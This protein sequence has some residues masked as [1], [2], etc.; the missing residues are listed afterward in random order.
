ME[1][2]ILHSNS[3]F[4]WVLPNDQE[5]KEISINEEFIAKNLNKKKSK[6]YKY[7]RGYMRYFLS[8]LF[9]INPLQVPL[10]SNPGEAPQLPPEFGFL[11]ISHTIDAL[12]I[13]WSKEKVG[14]D[15]ERYDRKIHSLELL[16]K[17]L[18]NPKT[19]EESYS[20]NEELRVKLLSMW[21]IKEA[22][23]K[24]D[25]TSI[26]SNFKNWKIN[27]EFTQAINVVNNQEVLIRNKRYKDWILGL[28]Y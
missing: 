27:N 25:N 12:A 26:A 2:C 7:S 10:Y 9:D 22:L 3:L 6:Q 28:A 18:N 17:F 23:V 4:I 11:S 15:I 8:K 5:Q 20:D 14:I 21:V 16:K 24:R 19:L 13:I 1:H